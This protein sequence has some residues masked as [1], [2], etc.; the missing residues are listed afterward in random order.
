SGTILS[1]V[2]LL[3]MPL[4]TILL[5]CSLTT[6]NPTAVGGEK[7]ATDPKPLSGIMTVTRHPMMVGFALWA[8]SHLVANGDLAS[9][10]LFGGL[11]ILSVGGMFHI[12]YR[13]SV[14]LGSDWGPIALTTSITPFLAVIQGRTKLDWAG[15]GLLRVVAGLALYAGLIFG[16]PWIAGV[17]V[18]MH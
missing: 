3:V 5:V 9:V 10:I 15:I 13:R 14:T 4:V 16:H 2:P 7:V 11:L 6:R 18:M 12:D 1:M 8:V 17:P